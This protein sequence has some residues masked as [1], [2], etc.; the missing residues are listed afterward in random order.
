MLAQPGLVAAL[1]LLRDEGARSVYE[2]TIAAELLALVDERIGALTRGRPAR[3]TRPSGR[4]P[5]R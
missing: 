5:A 3:R 4:G 1:E 2:G